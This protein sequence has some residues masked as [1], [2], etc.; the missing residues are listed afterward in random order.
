V[1]NE[2]KVSIIVAVVLVLTAFIDFRISAALATAYLI[3]YGV[4]RMR[5]TRRKEAS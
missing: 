3:A 2:A 5:K 1:E 4:N